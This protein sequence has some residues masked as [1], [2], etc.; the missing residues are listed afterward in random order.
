M[1]PSWFANIIASVNE[2]LK[3]RR[4]LFR[5]AAGLLVL[6]AGLRFA[7]LFCVG[8]VV[9]QTE[10]FNIAA[11]FATRG[12]LADAWGPGTGLTAHLSPGMPLLVGAIYRW[13]GVGTPPAEFTLACISL[14]FVYVTILALNAAFE[15][16]GVPPL[17]R[18]GAIA[19]LSLLPLNMFLETTQFRNWEGA[20]AAAGIAVCLSRALDLD[21]DERRPSWID[22]GV[23]PFGVGVLS[24]FSEAGALACYGMIGWLALRRRGWPGF[25]AVTAVSAVLLAALSYPW[26]LRNEAVFGEKVWTRTAF[27]I[28]FAE[29]FYDKA[30]RPADPRKVFYDRLVEVSPFLS[31]SALAALR[32]AGGEV[33]YSRLWTARTEAW[34]GQHP[35]AALKIAAR[36]VWEFY[37]QPPWMWGPGTPLLPIK[38]VMMQTFTVLGF[39]ALVV[40]L[41]CGDWRYL[42]VAVALVLP[43]L[44]YIFGQPIQRYRYPVDGLLVF[45]AADM[46]S[47]VARFMSNRRLSATMFLWR[48]LGGRRESNSGPSA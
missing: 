30:I 25:V 36:H 32:N 7:W 1:N 18:L 13:L 35:L 15:R 29:G 11:A 22:L 42:Y 16:L 14:A 28:N 47:R 37:M 31:P 45:L 2:K 38:Q 34:I 9:P 17:A 27:G 3:D 24:L 4:I 21:D 12:E 8:F 46:I 19:L 33:A 41:A 39:A 48:L 43:M 10:A 44:P 20:L 6:G 26:A 40:G 23:L 5:H